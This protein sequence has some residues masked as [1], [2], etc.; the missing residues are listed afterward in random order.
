M[1]FGFTGLLPNLIGFI[2]EIAL[3]EWSASLPG[4]VV[5]VVIGI[6]TTPIAARRYI[7]LS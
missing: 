7:P 4:I 6:V 5:W 1:L 3:G 2:T